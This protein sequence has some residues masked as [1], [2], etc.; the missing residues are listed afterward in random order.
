MSGIAEVLLN[1][2]YKVS[3]SDIA[4]TDVT[5]RLASLGA[6][7]SY[8]HRAGN[9]GSAHVVVISSAVK[10]DNPEITEARR[11]DIPVIPRAEMLAELMRLRWGIAI[12]GTHGKTTTTTLVAHVLAQGGL[13][14]TAVIGGKVNAF[15]SNVK[16]GQGRF[17]VAE[18]DESDGSFLRLTPVIAVVTNIDPEHMEH[19]GT[20]DNLLDSFT[21]FADSIPFYGLA[22]LCMDSENVRSILGR[23]EKRVVT[24]GL[25]HQAEYRPEEIR[26]EGLLSKFQVV[27]R[28]KELGEI[29]AP[30]PG[31]H[32]V[33]NALASVVVGIELEIPFADIRKGIA[34]YQ[35]IRRRFQIK[36]SS[37]DLLVVDDYGHHP[38]EIRATLAAARAAYPDRRI[39]LVFQP[40]RYSRTQ[41]LHR[42]FKDAF[43]DADFLILTG[44][45]SAGEDPIPGVTGELIYDDVIEAGHRA[46]T[47]VPKSADVVP[48]LKEVTKPGDV[49]ITMG[50]GDIYKVGEKFIEVISK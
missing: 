30:A 1:L 9:V 41:H 7:V 36:Y 44:I 28:G 4:E 5:R 3:G 45:Y 2:G 26:L 49:V 27:H 37:K 23:V 17:I 33:L 31:V 48:L 8:G 22:V 25:S 15:G 47:Y 32:N 18:A 40:H 42:E 24:Y 34:A 16:L 14:P 35:G 46:A 39:V 38:E 6:V 11:N 21:K 50:A 12:A 43:D 10:P 20:L 19:Y 13:D 29:T